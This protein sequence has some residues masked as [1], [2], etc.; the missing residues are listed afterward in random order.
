MY[1]KKIIATQFKNYPAQEV[2]WSPRLNCLTGRNG[3]GK[4][5]MLEAIY[6]LCMCRSCRGL[7]DRLLSLHDTSFFRLE[8]LFFVK[9]EAHKVVAKVEPGKR[10]VFEWND[11][12]YDR[13]AEH[14]G[15]LPVVAI[16]PEDVHIAME[17][18]EARR[19]FFDTTFSQIDP[20]YLSHL[21]TYNRL[22]QQRTRL[23]KQMAEQNVWRETLLETYDQ[24]M[25]EPATVVHKKRMA[26]SERMAPLFQRYYQRISEAQDE[27]G[28]TYRSPLKDTAWLDLQAGN[29]EK[30][31]V[32]QRTCSGLH[33][34]DWAFRIGEQEVKRFASQ[35]QLKS[36][37]L[38]LK[39]AQYELLR[40]HKGMAPILLLDDLFDKLDANRARQLLG[41]LYEQSFG[42]VFI[43]D[44]DESRI[45]AV[46]SHFH[47]DFRMFRVVNGEIE[48]A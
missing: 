3:M 13:L 38:S 21:I 24:Q 5:N 36:F 14:I 2:E 16:L 33:K 6:Y 12:P 47:E 39:L 8:G 29:R 48:K 19:N 23:I 20:E 28:Y 4:T 45:Q 34:D 32:L 37:I 41:L 15:K 17:G 1:L 40:Q 35:G 26:Y 25:E 22:L 9:E 27:V 42:Q 18:S 7:N 10:K 46:I 44:T 43:T 30:D 11:L 31:R